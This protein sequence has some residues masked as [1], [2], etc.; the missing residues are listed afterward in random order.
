MTVKQFVTIIGG[1]AIGAIVTLTIL[2]LYKISIESYGVANMAVTIT[3]FGLAAMI[4]LDAALKAGF[5]T[6]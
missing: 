3:L 5:L 1:L 6:K 2:L 4:G